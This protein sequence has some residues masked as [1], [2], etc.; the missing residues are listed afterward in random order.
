MRGDGAAAS[1]RRRPRYSACGRVA[2]WPERPR[3]SGPASEVR[4]ADRERSRPARRPGARAPRRGCPRR[5]L[6][7]AQTVVPRSASVPRPLWWVRPIPRSR[8]LNVSGAAPVQARAQPTGLGRASP[9]R[10]GTEAAGH[11]RACRLDTVPR[12][13]DA[14]ITAGFGAA[15]AGA[16]ATTTIVDPHGGLDHPL[17]LPE[18]RLIVPDRFGDDRGFFSETYRPP[19][20]RRGRDRGRVRPGQPLALGAAGTVR[21]LHYQ[22]PPFAQAKLVRVTRGPS[23]TWRS[24]SG[25]G[26]RRSA[27]TRPAR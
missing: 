27:A 6:D 11:G 5:G 1:R 19:R 18:V 10:R 2:G 15:R 3:R 20:P 12:R 21:G 17:S 7:A 26:R 22:L 9:A 23:S 8:C 14:A 25:A 16:G 13:R 4:V 24:T